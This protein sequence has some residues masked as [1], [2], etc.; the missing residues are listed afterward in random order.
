MADYALVMQDQTSLN[1][2]LFILNSVVVVNV[3]TLG[4]CYETPYF[5]SRRITERLRRSALQRI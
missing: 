3:I 2:Y 4:G 1:F 5:G